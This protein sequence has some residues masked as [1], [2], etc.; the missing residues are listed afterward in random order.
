LSEDLLVDNQK[1][2]SLKNFENEVILEGVR[3]P[4]KNGKNYQISI[5]HFQYVT[6][7]IQR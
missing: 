4:W 7:N 1:F 5:F 2:G 6:K 3:L